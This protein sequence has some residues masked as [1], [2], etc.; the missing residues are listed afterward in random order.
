MFTP[1]STKG[2]GAMRRAAC[3]NSPCVIFLLTICCPTLEEA[4][5]VTARALGEQRHS[6]S[7]HLR[8]EEG[9]AKDL[10]DLG[11]YIAGAD[12]ADRSASSLVAACLVDQ[13]RPLEWQLS[14]R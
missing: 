9:S 3:T 6:K 7:I 13:G 2:T 1:M 5:T 14:G 4:R 11:Q 8:S 10:Q 12:D